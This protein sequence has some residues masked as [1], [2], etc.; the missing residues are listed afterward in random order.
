MEGIDLNNV[1]AEKLEKIKAILAESDTKEST[2]CVAATKIDYLAA[3][4]KS[5][6]EA[7]NVIKEEYLNGVKGIKQSAEYLNI[8]LDTKD[9]FEQ[10]L[11][12]VGKLDGSNLRS[13]RERGLLSPDDKTTYKQLETIH[14][15]GTP[16]NFWD[17]IRGVVE[18]RK[19]IDVSE[20]D[21]KIDENLF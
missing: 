18:S 7:N 17:K 12:M 2:G 8:D 9:S 20:V 11:S 19:H 14:E 6:S 1:S 4:R 15:S 16:G 10:E 3:I 13:K 21:D 5:T